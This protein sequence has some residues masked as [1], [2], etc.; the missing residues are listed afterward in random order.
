M[1]PV[2]GIYHVSHHDLEDQGYM[3]VVII[4]NLFFY[5]FFI[6]KLIL[7]DFSTCQTSKPPNLNL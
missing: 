7:K 5:F 1:F 3:I 6:F 2:I 4:D